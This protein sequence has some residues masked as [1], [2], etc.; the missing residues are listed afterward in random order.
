[1]DSL[2]VIGV[3][4]LY[5][6]NLGY[7]ARAMRNFG[8]K[9]LYLVNV[10]RET[11]VGSFRYCAHARELIERAKVV[12]TLDEAL[13][14]VELAVG[15]TAISAKSKDN[16]LRICISPSKLR[17]LYSKRGGGLTALVFGRE[18]TGLSNE[19]LNLCDIIVNI[20]AN[21]EYPT[22]N[23]SHAAAILFYELYQSR[24]SGPQNLNAANREELTQLSR[25]FSELCET[26]G[27]PSHKRRIA[28][29]A[30]RNIIYRASPSRREILALLT[31]LRRAAVKIR[32]S[33]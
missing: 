28:E 9:E 33:K 15:T 27:I 8:V 10:D 13:L 30:L 12:R 3:G 18:S 6:V 22:L 32:N 5:S 31:P 25:I 20:P 1:M 23:L 29:R 24:C 16:L 26:T 4:I 11:I 21:P 14:G 17:E 19:E 2:R 7:L